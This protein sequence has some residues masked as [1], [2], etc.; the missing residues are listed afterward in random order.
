MGQKES[1]FDSAVEQLSVKYWP[2][3]F[4]RIEVFELNG[5]T[6]VLFGERHIQRDEI[7][8]V[9]VSP[10]IEFLNE[11]CASD[12]ALIKPKADFLVEFDIA[13]RSLVHPNRS[14]DPSQAKQ[15]AKQEHSTLE[16]V[17]QIVRQRCGGIRVHAVDVRDMGFC[18][19]YIDEMRTAS[20]ETK[21]QIRRMATDTFHSF[22]FHI[23][24]M[25][26]QNIAHAPEHLREP[27]S[28]MADELD[29]IMERFADTNRNGSGELTLEEL[30]NLQS[31]IVDFYTFFRVMRADLTSMRI[32]Y[33]GENHAENISSFLHQVHTELDP[34][35]PFRYWSLFDNL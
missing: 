6:I 16:A 21:E 25:S 9:D 13:R 14:I 28:S 4:M 19:W 29:C 18:D 31:I 22:L 11:F 35:A 33:I 17:R 32:I 3:N 15:N 5:A 23:K 12:D 7:E 24:R 30:F 1:C 26:L 10:V 27:L 34:H 8:R 20:G 2:V